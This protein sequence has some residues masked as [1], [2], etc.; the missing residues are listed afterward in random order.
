MTYPLTTNICI[1]TNYI[2][3]AHIH[4][5]GRCSEELGVDGCD[6]GCE[7]VFLVAR[8]R[9]DV[10]HFVERHFRLLLKIETLGYLGKA[11]TK[12]KNT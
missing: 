6:G 4:E 9:G 1:I 5:Q 12:G 2:R 3:K 8:E 7:E 10:L 11:S